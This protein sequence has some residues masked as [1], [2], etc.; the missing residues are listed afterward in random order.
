MNLHRL[1]N[2]RKVS[3]GLVLAASAATGLAQVPASREAVWKKLEPFAQPPAEFA[4]KF[5]PYRSP[6][7]FADGSLAKTPAE[8]AKRRDEIE[9]KWHQHL[10]PWPP[11]VQKPTVQKLEKVEREG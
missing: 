1:L 9:K 5:G 4:G 2:L 8:W 7:Q 11:M 10:G 3:F 6:L